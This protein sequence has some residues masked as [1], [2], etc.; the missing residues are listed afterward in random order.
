V[1][2]DNFTVG[3]TNL[4]PNFYDP[5]EWNYAVCGRYPGAVPAGATVSLQ[6]TCKTRALLKVRNLHILAHPVP[7]FFLFFYTNY[8]YNTC[9]T[10]A[11][12]AVY[13]RL[14]GVQISRRAVSSPGGRTF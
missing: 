4:P 3:L 9:I 13:L 10:C 6:C 14:A 8:L 7:Y 2:S 12:P 5:T 1:R 11:L